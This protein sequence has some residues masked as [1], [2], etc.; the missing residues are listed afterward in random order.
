MKKAI[1]SA[2]CFLGVSGPIHA[3]DLTPHEILLSDNGPRTKRFFFQD[4]DKRMSFRID[5]KMTVRRIGSAAVFRFKDLKTARVKLSKSQLNPEVPFDEKNLEAY[6]AAARALV[7]AGA[8]EAAL[9]DEKTDAIVIN[10][11]TSHQFVFTYKLFGFPY[12]RSITFLNY[13]E[14][15]QFIFDVT[16]AAPNY[17]KAYA[18]GYKV[19]NSFADMS[20]EDPSG[21]T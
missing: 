2:F 16:A 9:E 20:I 13:S 4:S 6:R 5:N 14:K 7:P 21:P 12:R 8:T 10:G 18:R 17:G 19:L 11:W 1:L 15:E 3:L